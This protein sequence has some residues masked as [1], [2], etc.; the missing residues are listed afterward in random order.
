[1]LHTCRYP[2]FT[3]HLSFRNLQSALLRSPK[4]GGPSSESVFE[5]KIEYFDYDSYGSALAI[6]YNGTGWESFYSVTPL[7]RTYLVSV[8]RHRAS[9]NVFNLFGSAPT[10]LV[11]VT[12]NETDYFERHLW[13]S[14]RNVT[15]IFTHLLLIYL[16]T[17]L[18]I[19][20]K[21]LLPRVSLLRS[22]FGPSRNLT[23]VEP[24]LCRVNGTN[25]VPDSDWFVCSSGA[26]WLSFFPEGPLVRKY[27]YIATAQTRT[28]IYVRHVRPTHECAV[29]ITSHTMP[30]FRASA[31][32]TIRHCTSSAT[33]RTTTFTLG[34]KS[35]HT[36]HL[37]LHVMDRLCICFCCFLHMTQRH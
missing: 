35:Y 16:F 28:L 6:F 11:L 15:P 17:Y 34:A 27:I 19:Y 29:F 8:F 33:N 30:R 20:H 3:Q 10:Y 13:V 5:T 31:E 37:Q 26:R 7:F 23:T 9:R 24:K 32:G 1:M 36:E 12:S 2:S 25:P 21:R 14:F 4:Q 22:V 18:F